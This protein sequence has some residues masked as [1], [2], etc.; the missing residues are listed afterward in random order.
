MSRTQRIADGLTPWAI[1]LGYIAMALGSLG[2]LLDALS[3]HSTTHGL[4]TTAYVGMVTLWL[5][6]DYDKR[7][8]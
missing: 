6:T 4:A 1:L 5:R 2:T 7:T 3:G 8:K